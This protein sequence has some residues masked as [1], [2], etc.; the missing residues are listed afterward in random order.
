MDSYRLLADAVLLL[1][2]GYVLFVVL[3]LPVILIGAACRWGWVRNFWFRTIHLSCMV[4]VGLEALVDMTCPLT[5]LERYLR[6]QAG[7]EM[8]EREFLAYWAEKLLYLDWPSWAFNV[9]HISFSIVLIATFVLIPPHWPWK[10][11]TPQVAGP[12]PV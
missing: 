7:E 2:A 10:P 8:Y 6:T 4:I 3:G 12:D 11:P 1:H 5:V 9:L